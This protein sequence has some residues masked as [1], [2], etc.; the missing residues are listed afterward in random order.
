MSGRRRLLVL[1]H[2]GVV[3]VNLSVYVPLVEWGWDLT[4][5][6]PFVAACSP[7]AARLAEQHGARGET[8]LVPHAVPAMRASEAMPGSALHRWLRRSPGPREGP[9]RSLRS[10][11]SPH[12][13][14]PPASRR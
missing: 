1:S 2:P 8:A 10:G 13:A 9:E 4:V 11:K 6:V 7:T 5:V 3:P 12:I 14:I